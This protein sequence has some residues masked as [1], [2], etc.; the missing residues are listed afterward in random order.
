MLKLA[1][2]ITEV[3]FASLPFVEGKA[4]QKRRVSSPAPV[5]IVSP[6]GLIAK[7]KTLRLWPVNVATFFIEGYF[8]ITMAF[9][10]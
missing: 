8:H 1:G 4:F 7:Y 2:S 9:S 6:S 10:E 3:S 5:T